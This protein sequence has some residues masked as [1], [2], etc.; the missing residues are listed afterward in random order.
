MPEGLDD[1]FNGACCCCL[2]SIA[3]VVGAYA[4]TSALSGSKEKE[5]GNGVSQFFSLKERAIS[6]I[7]WYQKEISPKIRVRLGNVCKYYPS[8][9]QYAVDAIN[10]KGFFLGII[11]AIWR[12]FRCN[13]WSKGGIDTVCT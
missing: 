10:K 13:P 5:K 8:C 1:P 7:K 2:G 3:A 12:L 11:F 9:S 4:L 6:K